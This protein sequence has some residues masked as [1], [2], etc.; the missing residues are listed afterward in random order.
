MKKNPSYLI[1]QIRFLLSRYHGSEWP[2][3]PRK[4]FLAL[5]A[6]MYQSPEQRIN[7][8]D[9]EKA[10]QFLE[11][12]QAPAIYAPS[13][14][15]CKYTIYVPNND[16]DLISKEYAKGK[17]SNRD[18]KKLKTGKQMNPYIVDTIQ[19]VWEIEPRDDAKRHADVL[20]RLAAEV[21]ALGL[22][23]DPVTS[24]GS[25]MN[26]IPNIEGAEIY[27]ANKGSGDERIK[28]PAP[29][30][31][32]DAKRHH[33]DFLKRVTD[34]VFKKPAPITKYHEQEYR[35][36]KR[37][38][39]ALMFRI[40]NTH[41]QRLPLPRKNVSDM[42]NKINKVMRIQKDSPVKVVALPSIGHKH[43]DGMIRRIALLVQPNASI[44]DNELNRLHGQMIDVRGQEYHL[45]LI[46]EDDGVQK[47][48]VEP[49][50]L[51]RTVTPVG[52]KLS[53]NVTRQ[54]I[55]ESILDALRTEGIDDTVTFVNFRKEPYWTG[56]ERIPTA[57][58][59]LHVEL[60]F[61]SKVKGPFV[62]GQN[63]GLGH[64]LFAPSSVPNVAYFA[65]LGGR[66]PIEKTITVAG[67]MRRS[68]MAKIG[69]ARTSIPEYISGHDHT[70]K[71]LQNN[72]RQAFWLPVDADCDGLIDHV[73][74][75]VQEGFERSIQDVFYS[76]RQLNDGHGLVLDVSFRGFYGRKSLEK[77]CGLFKSKKDWISATPYFMPWHMKK[78]Y[79]RDEQIRKECR[80]RGFG[81]IPSITDHEIRV[82]GKRMSTEAFH[83]IHNKQRPINPTGDALKISFKEPI[84]GPVSLGFGSHFGLGMFVPDDRI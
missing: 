20:C 37:V 39:K 43:A 63:Q 68:V 83:S 30:L 84:R 40:T 70:G 55:T 10:L 48:Y 78:N 32:D 31:L 27:M 66:P 77:R 54:E 14:E 56:L 18:V 52:I 73:A 67:L 1:F 5:V 33:S 80:K 4:L 44:G 57:S 59:S 15:G 69:N 71:P 62:I 51:W 50:R 74:V 19:Y 2:P 46:P 23:I 53:A 6:A 13:H 79:N 17:V 9:G 8:E 75:F 64:G 25:V 45:E 81:N 58:T 41:N 60:E 61:K 26:H 47:L 34:G 22:G 72:H 42:I 38:T 11:R 29:G 36:S 21:P 65:I 7:T 12:L 49:S 16:C 3:S 82:G 35:R 28:V 76:I 24:Y